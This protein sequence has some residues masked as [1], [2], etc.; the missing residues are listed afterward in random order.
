MNTKQN[1]G[2]GGK[3]YILKQQETNLAVFMV[4]KRE[5][6]WCMYTEKQILRFGLNIEPN[7]K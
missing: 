4:Q 5:L 2:T 6:C 1:T 7:I 3:K